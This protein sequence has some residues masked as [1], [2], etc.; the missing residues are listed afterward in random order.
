MIG[1][2]HVRTEFLSPIYSVALRPQGSWVICVTHILMSRSNIV[3]LSMSWCPMEKVGKVQ[4]VP[5]LVLSFRL[6]SGWQN[7]TG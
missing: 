2:I 6:I 7:S 5:F 3:T 1:A 4:H